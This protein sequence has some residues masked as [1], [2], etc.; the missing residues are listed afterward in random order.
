MFRSFVRPS[1]FSNFRYATRPN[2]ASILKVQDPGF[3]I[4]QQVVKRVSE[5]KPIELTEENYFDYLDFDVNTSP[6]L[7]HCLPS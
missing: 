7:V 6:V 3:D 2:T 1:S 5:L 4:K